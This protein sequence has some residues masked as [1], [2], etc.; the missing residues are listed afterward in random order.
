MKDLTKVIIKIDHEIT[1]K[2]RTQ[3]LI[4]DIETTLNHLI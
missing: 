1:H 3:T 2:T 4:I